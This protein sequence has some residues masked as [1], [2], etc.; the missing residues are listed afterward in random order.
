MCVKK[1]MND[2]TKIGDVY[3]INIRNKLKLSA[4]VT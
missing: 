2:F 3:N 4:P 1:N